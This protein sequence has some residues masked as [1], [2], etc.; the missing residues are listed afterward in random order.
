VNKGQARANRFAAIA[1]VSTGLLQQPLAS[2][3]FAASTFF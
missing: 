1:P 2:L 3:S